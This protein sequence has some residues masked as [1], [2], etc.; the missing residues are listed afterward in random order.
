MTGIRADQRVAAGRADDRADDRGEG[1]ES[2]G[3][4]EG[5][6]NDR[7]R[8]CLD[9]GQGEGSVPVEEPGEQRDRGGKPEEQKDVRRERN[10]AEEARH[11]E[12]RPSRRLGA[13]SLHCC[14]FDALEGSD[15]RHEGVSHQMSSLLWLLDCRGPVA[16]E[17]SGSVL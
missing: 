16:A 15:D 3:V 8:E 14:R 11:G 13:S 10:E 2:D 5:C 7:I 4:A 17:Q 1:G 6:E 9:V 12:G